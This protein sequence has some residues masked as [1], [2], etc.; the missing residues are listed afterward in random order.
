MEF[1]AE[2]I[3][4]SVLPIVLKLLSEREMYGYEIIKT[5]NERTEN[6]FQWK[7]GTLYPWLHRLEADGLITSEWSSANGRRRK[8]YQLS[9]RGARVMA[10]QLDEWKSF[11]ATVNA[12]LFG[13]VSPEPP[14]A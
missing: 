6:A 10:S 12:L 5:V 9:S 8:Y 4:G 7:E 1:S 11:S 13:P 14:P 3:K 2:M